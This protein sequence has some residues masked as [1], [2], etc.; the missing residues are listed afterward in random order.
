MQMKRL[1]VAG[2]PAA[3]WGAPSDKVFLAVHG[4]QSNK[5]DDVI[6]ILAEVAGDRGY[7]VISFD[8]PGHGDRKAENRRCDA[9][10]CVE[11]IG[12]IIEFAH[13]QWDDI[14]LFGCSIGAFFGML[15]LADETIRQA[16]FLSP[17]VDMKRLIENMMG[18]FGISPERLEAEQEIITPI[19][20]LSWDYYQYVVQ[21][22]V[23]WEKPTA[24]LCGARD[25]V[26]EPDVVSGFAG[27]VGANLTIVES[28]EHFFHTEEQ[29]AFYRK[30][31]K[32]RI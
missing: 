7:Q 4:D 6:T 20:T 13:T 23:R 1:P 24:M 27:R 12:R 30:W 16:L 25:A 31:L 9:R 26:C 28:G 29:L 14:S 22:P 15:A 19:K 3:I 11:D 18:W 10:S 8:L 5:A 32:M 21:H 17:V 2:I